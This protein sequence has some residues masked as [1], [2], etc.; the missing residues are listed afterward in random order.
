VLPFWLAA[1]P[2]PSPWPSP[3]GRGNTASR[4]A[5]SRGALDWRE[6]GR[7]FSLSPRERAGVRGKQRSTHQCAW[8][9]TQSFLERVGKFVFAQPRL[10]AHSRRNFSSFGPRPLLFKADDSPP[11]FL[12]DRRGFWRWAGEPVRGRNV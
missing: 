3:A 8:R 9:L 4:A 11:E 6:R 10:L 12:P 2:S 7:R 5:T 1:S